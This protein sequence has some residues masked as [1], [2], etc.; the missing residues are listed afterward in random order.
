MDA[1]PLRRRRRTVDRPAPV[2]ALGPDRRPAG[3]LVVDVAPGVG[4]H[5]VLRHDLKHVQG[6]GRA[7]VVLG[8][9]EV[10]LGLQVAD[11][12]LVGQR[13][14]PGPVALPRHDRAVVGVPERR[15]A[16]RRLAR[17]CD[18]D[19][20]ALHLPPV[21]VVEVA[22]RILR[23]EGQFVDVGGVGPAGRMRPG[24]MLVVAQVDVGEA[25]GGEAADVDVPRVKSHLPVAVA[26]EPGQVRVDDQ[27]RG[28]E[29]RLVRRQSDLVRGPEVDIEARFDA[30][31]AQVGPSLTGRPAPD[32]LAAEGDRHVD[33]DM[34]VAPPRRHLAGMP[35]Q[36]VVDAGNE[37]RQ[38]TA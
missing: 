4:D 24:D 35:I 8:D 26:A 5:H 12:L 7:L 25:G 18:L 33:I 29:R 32:E 1:Q 3:A 11:L 37:R 15:L 20:A 30:D 14:R 17:D 22:A 28:A 21:A 38:V 34:A 27:R 6:L 2:V 9:H 13:G 23:I 19:R 10:V 36:V 31:R 16:R